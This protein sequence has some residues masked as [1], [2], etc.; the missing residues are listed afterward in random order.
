MFDVVM[1]RI[2]GLGRK[3]HGLGRVGLVTENWTVAMSMPLRRTEDH[4]SDKL[5]HALMSRGRTATSL[6]RPYDVVRRWAWSRTT[7]TIKRCLHDHTCTVYMYAVCD[8]VNTAL[9]VF[10]RRQ[11][12]SPTTY[13]GG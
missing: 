2:V 8:S 5:Q 11:N 9:Y 4:Y 10:G 13:L 6:R 12:E 7:T 1:V 3:S